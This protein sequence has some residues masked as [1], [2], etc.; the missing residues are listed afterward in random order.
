MLF[1]EELASAV[2]G[3][4]KT[5]SVKKELIPREAMLEFN[6]KSSHIEIIAGIRRCGKSTLMRQFI[7]QTG[8]EFAYL[9]FEDPRIFG[10]EISDFPRLDEVFGEKVTT[11]FFDEI[12]NVRGWEVFVRQ[13]HDRGSK[14]FITGSNASLLS[15]ELGTR[16]TGR[17]LVH[18]VFPFS[19]SE[20]L[21]FTQ[22]GR[23]GSN[24]FI[25]CAIQGLVNV[26]R[27]MGHSHG[28]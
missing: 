16:L 2:S 20:F 28:V 21:N 23:K 24:E 14:V 15:N 19:Y 17:H 13:L 26:C 22:S 5:L 27:M 18:E 10:F 8:E 9:N 25:P 4:R 11:Y 3:Q 7:D 1:K 12:Q 6:P